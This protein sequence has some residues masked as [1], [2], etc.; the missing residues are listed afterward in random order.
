MAWS[1]LQSKRVGQAR[2]RLEGILKRDVRRAQEHERAQYWLGRI[3]E[4]KR[5]A[6]AIA[7]YEKLATHPSF[8][9][10]LALDRLR[11]LRPELA[12]G[13][14]KRLIAAASSTVGFAIQPTLLA[15]P[16]FEEAR[17][18]AQAGDPDL[19]AWSVRRLGCDTKTATVTLAISLALDAVGE[20]ADAQWRIRTDR[21]LLEGPLT[22]DNAYLWRAA[23]SRAFRTEIDRAAKPVASIPFSLPPLSE[24]NPLLIPTSSRGPA[25]PASL[26]SCRRPPAAPFVSSIGV[27]STFV[28]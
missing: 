18:Y 5:A 28:A 13:V 21:K 14:E 2:T 11:T 26:S 1:A 10:W 6:K 7:R 17:V 8:Y 15:R 16:E 23:Y 19:A 12:K 27:D 9:G 25:R 22:R 4:D 24:R 3:D 20:Y